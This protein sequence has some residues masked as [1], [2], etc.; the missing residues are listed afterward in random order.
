MRQTSETAAVHQICGY[1]ERCEWCGFSPLRIQA[2]VIPA[3]SLS[4]AFEREPVQTSPESGRVAYGCLH[5]RK[6][7]TGLELALH[8]EV[9]RDFEQAARCLIW[10]AE[11]AARRFAHGDSIRA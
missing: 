3:G 2:L 5:C 9:G 1:S 11:N 6:T 8:F 7:G 10:T 4:P